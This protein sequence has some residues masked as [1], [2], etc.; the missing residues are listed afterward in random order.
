MSEV[1]QEAEQLQR[2]IAAADEEC[3][4]LEEK[5]GR[6]R[7]ERVERWVGMGR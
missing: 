7:E 4:K 1:K 3:K 5:L 2:E 6:D